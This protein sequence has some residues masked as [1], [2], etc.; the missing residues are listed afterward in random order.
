MSFPHATA[1]ASRLEVLPSTGSTNADLRAHADD[2]AGW[3]HLSA[4]LTEDQRAGRGRLDRT[5]IAPAGSALA[6]SV[7]LRVAGVP[8]EQRGWIPLAAGVAMAEAVAAQL[9]GR[10]VGVKWPNDV[11]VGDRKICG[12]LAEVSGPDAIVVGSG[13]NTAMT[14]EELP[15]P[16]A[17]SFAAEGEGCDVDLLVAGY[18]ARLDRAVAGLVEHGSA[19]A[20]G[21]HAAVSARC[22]TL[23]RSVRATLPGGGEIVGEA[24][25]IGEDGG[26]VILADGVEHRVSA[27]DIVHLR[28]A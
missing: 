2:E 24:S 14:A 5:W 21:L 22:V 4:L 3:P 13:V 12:I 6:L 23:G 18:L 28:P 16:T 19:K 1:A 15:V 10:E 17:T 11:L 25:A 26:L 9:P 20:S 7:L 8:A 27:G